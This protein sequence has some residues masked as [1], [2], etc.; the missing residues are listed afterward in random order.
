VGNGITEQRNNEMT[1]TE[2]H[3]EIAEIK[4][5]GLL[6]GSTLDL[7]IVLSYVLRSAVELTKSSVGMIFVKDSV[8]GLFK[9]GASHGLSENFVNE[10]NKEPIQ[11][12]EGLTGTIAQTGEAIYIRE[13]SSFDPRIA[14]S[15]IQEESFNSFLGVPIFAEDKI[16]GVMN[17]LTRPPA[18]LN[19]SVVDVVVAISS[20]VGLSIRNAQLYKE[21][22]EANANLLE[23]RER[24]RQIAENIDEVFW[25]RSADNSEVLYINPA[26]EKVWGQTCQGLYDNPQSFLES[27]HDLDKQAVLAEF[28]NYMNSGVFDLE[29]RVVRPDGEIRWVRAKSSPVLDDDGSIVRHAGIAVDL[30]ELKKTEYEL[31]KSMK[32]VQ[33]ILDN[34]QDAY[35]QVDI[36]GN[37]V[38]ANLTAAQVYGY[39]SKEMI[40]ISALK[41]Y[42]DANE[43]AR[44]LE[45]L[46]S[47]G[48]VKDFVTKG[49]RK[50]GSDFWIS[51]SS[52]YVRNESG[53]IV[54]TE[55]L[56]RDITERIELT[57]ELEQ[58]RD[59]LTRRLDQTVRA[60]S[61]I[62]ELRDPYTAG[63]QDKVTNLACAIADAMGLS[64]ELIVNLRIGALI[65]DVGKIFIPSDILNKPGEISRL[66]Y[67]IIQTHAEQGYNLIK[68]IDM[69]EK[70]GIMVYQ[71]HERLD[72]SGYPRGIAGNDIILESRILAVADVVEAMISH[73]PYRASL[74]INA[75]I[76]EI[77]LHRGS[78]YD[79]DVVDA[80]VRLIREEGY[81]PS[82]S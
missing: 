3:R 73:R 79:S 51:I 59:Q 25:L 33:R 54:G 10:Y 82:S 52:Q 70:I 55:G 4:N 41:L 75:A 43:R 34:L 49:L 62:G 15:I 76:E 29:Y 69:P 78:K 40:G 58:Q 53:E 16:I 12:G 28:E 61:R 31:H 63:H 7:D 38:M 27:V 44:L 17:I 13:S 23:S 46:R 2:H 8:S 50:D 42:A 11:L 14:R 80:C 20:Q 30:S 60:I 64:G 18:I 67:Q 21:Q 22:K 19:E 48:S 66:E 37:V 65:H 35:F 57:E 45:E 39:N 74:G 77:L 72:G 9:W 71:H 26:Y 6:A 24:F 32:Q 81:I 5:I 36:S 56:V 68:D 47:E 1:R